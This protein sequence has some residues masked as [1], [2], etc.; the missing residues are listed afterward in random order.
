[1]PGDTVGNIGLEF[2]VQPMLA[3][4]VTD[5]P[6]GAA[7]TGGCW[8]EPKFDGYRGLVFIDDDG[9]RVQ[10]RNGHD[11]TRSFPDIASA[12]HAMLPTGTVID[13]ELLIW[14]EDGLDFAA[15]QQRL[16]S[17]ASA[18]TLADATPASI[19]VFDLLA[20]SGTDVRHLP[21]QERRRLMEQ[22]FGDVGPPLQ[23]VPHSRDQE[24]A[25]E[26][27]ETYRQARVGIEGLVIKGAGSRYEPGR[28]GW[29]KLRIR[30]TVEVLV[31]AVTGTIETP[32]RLVLGYRD[33]DG[34]LIMAGSTA[35]LNRRQCREVAEHLSPAAPGHAWPTVIGAGRLGQWGGKPQQV[36]LVEPTL[37][38][39]VSGD[40]AVEQG[41]WRHLTK[42]VRT[43]P[44]LRPE[45]L[46]PLA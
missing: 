14:S 45:D 29:A 24:Q 25:R 22:A 2:P 38:V 11:I 7:M 4:S 35:T 12:A 6:T 28:R 41:R 37:I 15:L 33:T 19:I 40:N 39:E 18:R 16:A 26:W 13:G 8:Y 10:S 3:A 46:P 36:T 21:L 42:F 31:G 44:D 43:R 32:G 17:R 23:L 20:I 27:M 34:Q 5:L 1:M 9:A 30:E